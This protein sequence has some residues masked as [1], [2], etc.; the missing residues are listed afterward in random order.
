MIPV[1]VPDKTS[2][3]ESLEEDGW[4]SDILNVEDHS[5]KMFDVDDSENKT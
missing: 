5:N 3:E 1:D 2:G 4:I